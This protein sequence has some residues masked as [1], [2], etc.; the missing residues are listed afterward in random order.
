[1][2][3]KKQLEKL[4]KRQK[5]YDQKLAGKKGFTRPGSQKKSGH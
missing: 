2:K 4:D 1:M 3:P 5:D